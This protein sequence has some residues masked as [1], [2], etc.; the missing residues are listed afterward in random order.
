VQA[1][2]AGR[3]QLVTCIHRQQLADLH[4]R[5]AH[6]GQVSSRAPGVARGQEQIAEPGALAGREAASTLAEHVAG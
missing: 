6:L 2:D 5:A 3:R 4:R 1:Q